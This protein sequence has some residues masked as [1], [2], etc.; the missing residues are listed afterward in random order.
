MSIH[1]TSQHDTSLSGFP[2]VT[3]VMVWLDVKEKRWNHRDGFLSTQVSLLPISTPAVWQ[4]V[5][6]SPLPSRRLGIAETA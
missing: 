1:C 2:D 4:H 6:N 5:A 3:H